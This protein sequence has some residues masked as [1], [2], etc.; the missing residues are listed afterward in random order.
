MKN[1]KVKCAHCGHQTVFANMTR[2]EALGTTVR[3]T[4]C[5]AKMKMLGGRGS[6]LVGHVARGVTHA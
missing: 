3:C 4:N 2:A 1:A 5:R 6:E